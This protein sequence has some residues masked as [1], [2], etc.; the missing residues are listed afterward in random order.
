MTEPVDDFRSEVSHAMTRR[1]R[2]CIWVIIIGLA[3]FLAYAVAYDAVG[4]EAVHGGVRAERIDGKLVRHYFL[5]ESGDLTE[6]SRRV[7]IYSAIH[8][9]SIWVTV[10]G[11]LLAMLTLA[12]DRIVSSMRS[13]II[14]GRT[15]I[16]MVAT[17]VTLISLLVT[18]WFLIYMLQ[19]LFWPVPA[20][21]P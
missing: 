6:T 18:A 10:G 12:K 1:T 7:W 8:S 3:N 9:T 4:G 21:A 19:H 2:I 11:I 16:T 5:A 20:G 17:V 13:T 15:F 14:R